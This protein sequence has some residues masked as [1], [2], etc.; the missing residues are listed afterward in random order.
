V[1]SFSTRFTFRA[2]AG[3]DAADGLAF[4]IQAGGPT[5]LG[6]TGGGLG[7]AGIPSSVAV[8]F[9]LYDND[10]EGSTP[11]ACYVGGAAPTAAGSVNVAAAGIDLH[12]GDPFGVSMDYE[13]LGRCGYTLTD[14][15]TAPSATTVLRGQRPDGGGRDHGVRRLHR[16]HGRQTATF[17]VL[18]WV[19]SPPA[20]QA[21]SAPS[22]LGATPASATSVSLAWTNR[23]STRPA[24][25]WTGPPTLTSPEPADPDRQPAR[26]R[27]VHR[28]RRRAGPGG[29]FYYRSAPSTPPATRPTRTSPP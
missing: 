18:D 21:P 5:A 3:A 9:D 28:R 19:F 29:T 25:A 4:V 1:A 11:P 13:R 2:S 23:S 17:D 16:R 12:S 10:G 6:Q 15:T 7:Y 20:A 22:G 27:L 8:K 26:S 14:Q 24:S